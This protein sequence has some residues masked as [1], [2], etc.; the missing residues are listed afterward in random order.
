MNY[1]LT[2]GS[3]DGFYTAVYDAY[4]DQESCI[5]SDQNLQPNLFDTIKTVHTDKLKANKI[6]ARISTWDPI[7]TSDVFLILKYEGKD[8]EQIAFGYLKTLIREKR[9]VRTMFSDE[10]AERAIATMRKITLEVHHFTGF[11]RFTENRDGILYAPISPDHD[12]LD[13]LMPH[14]E[15]RLGKNPFL[16][17]DTKRSK[18]GIWNGKCHTFAQIGI[19][20]SF[21]P[22]AEQDEWEQLWKSYYQHVNIALRSHEKQMKASM[23][24][25]YWTYLPEKH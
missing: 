12:I 23:P 11:L 7:V 14:F 10:Q 25:R 3:S 21:V 8:R 22:S 24:V 19:T 17:H 9:S 18:L 15:K 13:L 5:T 6:K 16:I 20:P 2:D 4:P 1:Y